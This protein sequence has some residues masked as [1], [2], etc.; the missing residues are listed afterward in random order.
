MTAV[1]KGASPAIDTQ[2]DQK[3]YPFIQIVVPYEADDALG[4][5]AWN[6]PSPHPAAADKVAFAVQIKDPLWYDRNL[7]HFSFTT[8]PNETKTVWFDLR[9]RILPANRCLYI[10]IACSCSKFSTKLMESASLKLIYKDAKQAKAE[11]VA[12][13]FTQVRDIYAHLVEEQPGLPEFE[14]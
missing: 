11:H 6:S 14:M 12:D 5:T 10:T 3:G 13:R 2:A 7:A 4:L 8:D 1:P 9:D